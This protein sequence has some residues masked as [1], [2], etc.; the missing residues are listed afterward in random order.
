M[1]DDTYKRPTVVGNIQRILALPCN[2]S[3]SLWVATL[4]AA[5]LQAAW[6]I[7]SPDPKHIYHK[8]RGGSLLCDIK[9]GI[10]DTGLLPPEAEN[11][12]KRFFFRTTEWYDRLTWYVFLLDVADDALINWTSNVIKFACPDK[13]QSPFVGV[14]GAEFGGLD[15]DA[16]WQTAD[17]YAQE[18]SVYYP[19]SPSSVDCKPG[20]P[21][22]LAGHATWSKAHL[23]TKGK[24]ETRVICEDTG[25]VFDTDNDETHTGNF[26]KTLAFASGKNFTSNTLRFSMQWRFVGSQSEPGTAMLLH[27]GYLHKYGIPPTF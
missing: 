6:D 17:F 18:G 8:L 16:R 25:A 13:Y 9:G 12:A 2:P 22:V 14:G 3:P 27:G 23:D 26:S 10:E 19:A 15:V 7:L 1:A 4:S 5:A 24:V 21:W 11:K 20:T